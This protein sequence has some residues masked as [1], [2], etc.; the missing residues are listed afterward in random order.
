MAQWQ[1]ESHTPH[2]YDTRKETLKTNHTICTHGRPR[3]TR[4]DPIP[5]QI[6]YNMHVSVDTH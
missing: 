6:G 5:P 2:I 3:T 1:I 4:T